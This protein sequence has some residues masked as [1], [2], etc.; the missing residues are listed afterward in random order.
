MKDF[1]WAYLLFG[2]GTAWSDTER[3]V[4]SRTFMLFCLFLFLTK[5]KY[6]KKVNTNSLNEKVLTMT[7]VLFPGLLKVA[8]ALKVKGT[9]ELFESIC[10]T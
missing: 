3:T 10:F 1:F 2:Y 4:Q 8:E 6:K 9:N 5:D 7:L